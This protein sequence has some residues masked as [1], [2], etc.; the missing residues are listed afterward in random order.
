MFFGLHPGITTTDL[1]QA[2]LEGV[3]FSVADAQT[4]LLAA[5]A[6]PKLPSIIGG[7][8]RN[9]FWIKLLAAA[10]GRPVALTRA[11][12][13]GPAFGAARLA[14]LAV[15]RE[16]IGEICAAPPVESIVEPDAA[17]MRAYAERL[18]RFR[19]LYKALR[20]EFQRGGADPF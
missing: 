15:T 19:S 14:R 17:L 20:P 6:D 13:K 12:E 10:L 18:P 4:A 3:A 16:A 8:A 5:G 1:V 2:V 9:K 11:G 7:G